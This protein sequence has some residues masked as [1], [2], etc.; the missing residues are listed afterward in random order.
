MAPSTPDL[1]YA[2]VHQTSKRLRIQVPRLR[3]DEALAT[4][5]QSKL[6]A[7][8]G[9]AAVRINRAACSVIIHFRDRPSADPV[10]PQILTL[11]E[12]WSS[13]PAPEPTLEQASALL[14]QRSDPPSS[15]PTAPPAPQPGRPTDS[16]SSANSA[17][18]TNSINTANSTDSTN[19]P[20]E[21]Q[22][23]VV[24]PDPL[25][26]RDLAE[27]LGV[28]SQCITPRRQ[29]PTFKDW[30]QEQDPE[31]VAWCYE[32]DSGTFHPLSEHPLSEIESTSQ[33]QQP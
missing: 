20:P 18:L 29:Q 22:P 26:Q 24:L 33:A 28:S 2:V 31:G 8:K 25:T 23:T 27:R 5:L 4:T 13:R 21:E 7:V 11:L 30:S 32:A 1:E 14:A 16:A 9:V 6:E 12:E 19:S 17:N 3:N 15:I 10:P